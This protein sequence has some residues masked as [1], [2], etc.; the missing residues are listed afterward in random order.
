VIHMKKVLIFSYYFPPDPAIGSLRIYGLAK[1]LPHFGWEPIILTKNSYDCFVS[2]YNVIRTPLFEY[3]SRNSFKHKIGLNPKET[4]KKQIGR[5]HF[6]DK[7]TFLDLLLNFVAETITYPDNQKKW[8][9]HAFEQA[10]ELLTSKNIDAI[11]STSS[12]IVSHI[13]A[14]D[15]QKK[16]NLPWIADLR[17]LWTQ[18][19][20]YPYSC[21]RRAL[22]RRLEIKTLKTSN[23]LTTVSHNLASELETLHGETRVYSIPNGFNIDEISNEN[24]I[25]TD[26]F[27]I[28]YTG[29]LYHGK[30]D[31]SKLFEALKEL[32]DEQKLDREDVEV[33][34][35][36]PQEDWLKQEIEKYNL[37]GIVHD[38]G[39]VSRKI[40]LLKQRESQILLLLL[41][42]HPSEVGVYT[43]K[44]FEYMSSKRPI[45]AI[46][47]QKG[48]VDELLKETEAGKF[49]S[50][51]EDI[52]RYIL[53]CYSEYK[54]NGQV[55]YKGNFSKIEKYSQKEMARKFAEVLN[56]VS[57]NKN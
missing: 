56:V 38:Y 29:S 39:L 10:D 36:G 47:G 25:S 46:G 6:K 1:Y 12:P 41:W 24:I 14:H 20:Y 11:L 17:D 55:C 4:V 2:D 49:V 13:I 31:P 57:K 5:S 34:F 18:N 48:V 9:S 26:K 16:H 40:S 15:L 23:A 35:Y 44:I 7:K 37:Q 51:T 19:H 22:E 54:L 43:G 33:L 50:S 42:D 53:E 27:T 8:Y 32:I 21:V 28:T 52:K 3:S 30:R 45:L